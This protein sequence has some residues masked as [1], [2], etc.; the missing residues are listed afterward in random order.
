MHG[1]RQSQASLLALIK[2]IQA[3]SAATSHQPELTVMQQSNIDRSLFYLQHIAEYFRVRTGEASAIDGPAAV[4]APGRRHTLRSPR[5]ELIL[6]RI[7]RQL[8]Q[9]IR[10]RY[11]AMYMRRERLDQLSANKTNRAQRSQKVRRTQSCSNG[12]G[13]QKHPAAGDNQLLVS[14]SKRKEAHG[15]QSR[16]L[17][18]SYRRSSERRAQPAIHE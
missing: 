6:K 1:V 13:Q 16:L 18:I 17:G 7:S 11:N 15:P 4:A 12:G 14:D 5:S 9:P 3:T 8:I 2:N 10:M